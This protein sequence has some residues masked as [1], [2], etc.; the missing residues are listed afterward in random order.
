MLNKEKEVSVSLHRIQRV[1][2]TNAKDNIQNAASMIAM[3]ITKTEPAMNHK[4]YE[5]YQRSIK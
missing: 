5:D 4:R 2:Q 1:V 3:S